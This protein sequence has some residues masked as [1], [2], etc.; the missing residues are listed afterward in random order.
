M[1]I[2][3]YTINE[4][5]K[6]LLY[7]IIE[8]KSFSLIRL[9]DGGV[10]LIYAYLNND[11]EHLDQ[12]IKKEGLPKTG[13]DYV[14]KLWV[15]YINSADFIDTPEVYY[16][17]GFWPRVKRLDK[18]ISKKTTEKLL[19]WKD[20]YN[21]IGFT[22]ENY[23]NPESNYLMV[24]KQQSLNLI[25]L[26]HDRKFCII[27]TR[28]NLKKKL[29]KKGFDVDIIEIVGQYDNHYIKSFQFVIDEI[30]KKAKQ[31]DFFL[32]AAGE[33][34]RIYS[35]FIKECGGRSLDLGFVADFWDG[36][37]IHSRLTPFLTRYDDLQLTLTGNGRKYQKYI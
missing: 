37:N 35:G 21:K 6:K 10:K 23:C 13:L 28:H 31:Y 22:N 36:K 25:S 30:E 33:L 9:G 5:L 19:S 16:N 24:I 26:M 4:I 12:I 2:K 32:V 11:Y 17:G 14:L 15:R 18:G 20:L 1:S 29:Q 27:T 8:D 34:G 3:I 7:C